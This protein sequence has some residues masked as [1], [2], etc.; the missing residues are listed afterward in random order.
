MLGSTAYKRLSRS[1]I[2]G[3]GNSANFSRRPGSKRLNSVLMR[4][5]GPGNITAERGFSARTFSV[6]IA[7][8]RTPHFNGLIATQCELKTRVKM[9]T[10]AQPYSKHGGMIWKLAAG[11]GVCSNAADNPHWT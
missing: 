5:P 4:K 7:V 9:Q 1:E 10:S 2:S 3:V 11:P 8:I 6:V